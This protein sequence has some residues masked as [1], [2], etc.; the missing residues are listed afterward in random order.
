MNPNIR[1]VPRPSPNS[2]LCHVEIY[3][4]QGVVRVGIN[5]DDKG[6]CEVGETFPLRDVDNLSDQELKEL[7][8]EQLTPVIIQSCPQYVGRTMTYEIGVVP[9]MF[10]IPAMAH[11]RGPLP[12]A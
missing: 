1:R 4:K 6:R 10:D 12:S 11:G 9:A 2:V 5:P 8:M 7:I 3:R